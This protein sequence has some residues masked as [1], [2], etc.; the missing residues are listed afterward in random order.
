MPSRLDLDRPQSAV[1]AGR[2]ACTRLTRPGDG[3][4]ADIRC[5]TNAKGVPPLTDL[6]T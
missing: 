3:I 2:A 4:R 5:A 6:M 1:I